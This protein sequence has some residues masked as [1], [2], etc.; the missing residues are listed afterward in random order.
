MTE[1]QARKI[2]M[3]ARVRDFGAGHAAAFTP[4]TQAG[5]LFAKVAAAVEKIAAQAAAQAT[6][7]GTV[8]EGNANRRLARENLRGDLEAVSRTA[9]TLS[10]VIANVD[11]KFRMPASSRDQALLD[12]A[13][14]FA[15]DAVP[16]RAQ[17]AALE[18]G[19]EFF[20][21]LEADIAAFDQALATQNRGREARITT[22]AA[23]SSE[24]TQAVRTVRQLDTIVR[25]RFTRDAVTLSA[26]AA[27]SRVQRPGR[28][29]RAGAAAVATG[30]ALT[31]L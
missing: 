11:A 29:A 31:A 19:D 12:A 17:F 1:V 9:R 13:R 8:R 23:V 18:L 3:L 6:S 27:A 5:D 28:G 26:W 30:E 25:N 10:A 14:A 21:K 24:V 7:N 2:E 4:G 15:A 20:A 16:F 22:T